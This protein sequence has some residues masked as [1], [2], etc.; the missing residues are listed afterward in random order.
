MVKWVHE[1]G[2]SSQ[3]GSLG[4]ARLLG[5]KGL[6]LAEMVSLGLPVPPG[7]TITTE[8]C[9]YYYANNYKLSA[10]LR[11]QVVV[12]LAAVEQLVGKNF[13]SP[14]NP[15]LVS[16]CA[17][18]RI[19]MPGM[20]DSV[21]NLGL[22]DQTVAGLAAC[23][24]DERFAYD[25]YRR[26]IQMYSVAVLGVAEYHFS[27]QLELLLEEKGVK[28]DTELNAN[29][30][31][32]L[33][34]VYKSV[35]KAELD[36]DFPQDP[37]AQLWRAI[38]AVFGSW[39]N[40]RAIT[41]RR[42]HEIPESGGT[43]VNVRAMV[44]GNMGDMSGTGVAFTRNPSTGE[45]A[46]F[47]EFLINAQGEDVVAGLRTPQRLTLASRLADFSDLPSMEEVMPSVF[48]KF[49]AIAEKLETHYADMQD[50]GFTVEQG[51]LWVLE[52]RDGKRTETAAIKIAVDLVAEGLITKEDAVTRVKP[53]AFEH[54]LK[55]IID[56]CAVH[57]VIAEGLPASAGVASGRISLFASEVEALAARGVPLILVAEE[58]SHTDIPSMHAARGV[59]TTRGGMVS[60]AA[61]VAR[62]MGRAC[63][64]GAG[65]LQLN[66]SDQTVR[67]GDRIFHAGDLITVDGSGGQVLA[68]AAPLVESKMSDEMT[69][70]I[71]W[72]DEIANEVSAIV[73]DS[74]SAQ[75]AASFG[76]RK[77]VVSPF[78][79]LLRNPDGMQTLL[80]IFAAD[81]AIE[82]RR[83]LD[84]LSNLIRDSIVTLVRA[85]HAKDICVIIGEEI[86]YE[87][88]NCLPDAAQYGRGSFV[89]QPEFVLMQHGAFHDAIKDLANI[90][91]T[92][93]FTIGVANAFHEADIALVRKWLEERMQS[94]DCEFLPQVEVAGVL[95][96]PHSV[97]CYQHI[98]D[99][100]DKLLI[101]FPALAQR[102][103]L[104]PKEAIESYQDFG[105]L[106][107]GHEMGGVFHDVIRLLDQ[108]LHL[109]IGV[110]RTTKISAL[111]TGPCT[112]EALQSLL[113]CGVSSFAV[114][115]ATLPWAIVSIAHSI[116]AKQNI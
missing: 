86:P 113:D 92:P 12:S 63:V 49:K 36:E 95:D 33:V 22:N 27:E 51:R 65:N 20:M 84:V 34:K 75:L 16:V 32:R 76:C 83:S 111:L 66:L 109:P 74:E 13:G 72:A 45:N 64:T 115:A 71:E 85:V 17:G 93:R 112:P 11:Q 53:S 1:F 108:S 50:I 25:S 79:C 100:T 68:G 2:R 42:L 15:L 82:F 41:Y 57:D 29:D 21:L 35:V 61:V 70:I 89:L 54:I 94:H 110:A 69:H 60:H 14:S 116:V 107:L 46:F 114:P 24:G 62:G 52:S 98:F 5:L 18:A 3:P 43:A 103:F 104:L 59:L 73:Y 26:L 105:Y 38:S 99:D 28:L 37:K 4:D 6:N 56:P 47:G 8:A 48:A 44:F 88:S 58:I 31:K 101:D 102:L 78:E 23:S 55:P 91:C 87:W 77:I 90:E 106:E 40:P 97:L 30:L 9:S 96:S 10:G 67:V 19:S 7:F 81:S 80:T 39:M